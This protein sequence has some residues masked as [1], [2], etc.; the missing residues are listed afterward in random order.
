[1]R[2][3]RRQLEDL[4]LLAGLGVL[5]FF[6]NLLPFSVAMRGARIIGALL[7]VIHRRKCIAYSNLRVAFGDGKSVEELG[8]IIRSNYQHLAMTC[9][10]ILRLPRLGRRYRE[11][12]ID[13]GDDVLRRVE[14]YRRSGRGIIFLAAHFGNWEIFHLARY[15]YGEGL[16]ILARA[17]RHTLADRFLS[18]IR[19]SHGSELITRGMGVRRLYE[20]LERGAMAGILADQ[21]AGRGG[22]FVPFFGRESSYPRGV[23]RLSRETGAAILPVF[24]VRESGF[25]HRIVL[26]EDI[27]CPEASDEEACER[28]IF[29]RYSRVLEAMIRQRPELWL[30]PYRRWKS[31]PNRDFLILS[32]G[33]AGHEKQSLA[34]FHHIVARRGES[35]GRGEVNRLK[36]V[37][38]HYR[39][40]FHRR[41]LIA[42]GY[43]S[44][45][46]FPGGYAILKA[47]LTKGSSRPAQIS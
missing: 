19:S 6:L 15:Y 11:R 27:S 16:H 28:E 5:Q 13:V 32:D 37:R 23:A 17:Q 41:L 36:T 46:L 12:Y 35:G 1:M 39:S 43:V 40:E 25:R 20:K 10:E 29:Q 47:A 34:L 9:V 44:R 4:G 3:N 18:R 14:A 33:K 31:S 45:G 22:V 38:L 7:A 21:D 42:T 26:G 30:W 24:P 8:S 2:W